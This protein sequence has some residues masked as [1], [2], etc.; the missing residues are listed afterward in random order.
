MMKAVAEKDHGLKGKFLI[1]AAA[2]VGLFSS[3][4]GERWIGL[5]GLCSLMPLLWLEAESR[6]SAFLSIFAF[7]LVFSRGILPGAAVFFR[8]G[9]LIRAFVLWVSSSFALALP[10]GLLWS[11][12]DTRKALRVVLAVLSSIPPP[13]GLIGWGNSLIT[14]GLFFP[15]TGWFGL[16]FM[17][18]LYSFAALSHRLRRVLIIAVLI[19]VPFLNVLVNAERTV[20]GDVT[21]LGVDTSFGRVASGSGDFETQFERERLVFQHIREMERNGELEGVD[22]VVLPETIVGRM[23]PS[24]RWRWERFLDPF[25]EKGTVFIAGAEIPTDRGMKYDNTMVSFE[26]GGSHQVAKQRFPVLFSMYLPFADTGANGYL[27]SFGEV[28]MMNIMGKRLGVLVCYEQFLTWPFL[29]LLS[30]S[31]DAILAS[32]NLWWCKDTSLPGIQSAT[33]RLL[34]ALFGVSVVSSVNK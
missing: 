27:S 29:T 8:D 32:S 14:A 25:A 2:G 11:D 13:L 34:A 18:M 33:V 10:W 15:G 31:P 3:A 9:S 6:R 5:A 19:S 17:L 22:I 26:G 21:V 1:L 7:Y 4:F 28:S 20:L 23:N 24:V 12:L 16:A 30:Q